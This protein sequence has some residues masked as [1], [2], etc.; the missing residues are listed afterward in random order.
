MTRTELIRALQGLTANELDAVISAARG[1]DTRD[2]KQLIEREL[3]R[4]EPPAL[5]S[6]EIERLALGE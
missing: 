5:N 6:P 1:G 3:S 4:Q 2:V